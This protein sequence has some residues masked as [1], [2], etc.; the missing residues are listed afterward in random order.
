MVLP[1]VLFVHAMVLPPNLCL[2][3]LLVYSPVLLTA[4][5]GECTSVASACM[6]CY[7]VTT[8]GSAMVSPPVLL[9]ALCNGVTTRLH[10][11]QA[12]LWC[13]H[14]CCCMLCMLCYGVP[15]SAYCACY[16]EST[17]AS[18]HAMVYP[19]VPLLQALVFPPAIYVLW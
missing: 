18:C 6:Q 10:A 11:L 14:Q 5:Y 9:L 15:T 16:G 19:P 12:M 3:A 8:N 2:S 13:F 4:S 17:N 1:P 7:G